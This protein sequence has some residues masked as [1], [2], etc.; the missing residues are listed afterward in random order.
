MQLNGVEYQAYIHLPRRRTGHAQWPPDA[1]LVKKCIAGQMTTAPS[2]EE[3]EG[4]PS[5]S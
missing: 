1:L 3:M 5:V 4:L 2:I